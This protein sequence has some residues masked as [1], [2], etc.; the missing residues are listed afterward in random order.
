MFGD[1]HVNQ[2][3]EVLAEQAF[4]CLVPGESVLVNHQEMVHESL[5]LCGEEAMQ[6]VL[7]ND[8]KAGLVIATGRQ[9]VNRKG[10]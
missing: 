2:W 6:V 1:W 8:V 5:F 7:L 10:G 9:E 4:L 3:E